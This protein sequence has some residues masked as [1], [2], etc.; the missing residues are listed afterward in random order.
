[1]FMLKEPP[2]R[3]LEQGLWSR[4]RDIN[5]ISEAVLTNSKQVL[6]KGGGLGTVAFVHD[7]QWAGPHSRLVS[8][9][10]CIIYVRMVAPFQ[11]TLSCC[12]SQQNLNICTAK[13]SAT[14]IVTV[15]PRKAFFYSKERVLYPPFRTK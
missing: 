9:Q 10:V 14:S 11:C 4:Q 6:L 1:M 3:S 7:K 15:H 13:F 2:I 5:P 12:C 8:I